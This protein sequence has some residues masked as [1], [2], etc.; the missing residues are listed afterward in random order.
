MKVTDIQTFV[1]DELAGETQYYWALQAI[2]D[3]DNVGPLS[4]IVSATTSAVPPSTISDLSAQ[5][6]GMYSA[7]LTFTAPGDDNE[8][9]TAAA[10]EIR[11][12]DYPL[13]SQ[14]FGFATLVE[15]PPT[16]LA[17]GTEQSLD[18]ENLD[19]GVL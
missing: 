2:D 11:Y 8:T 10:Y 5:A 17:A 16:P 7:T 6:T 12:A 14:N 9:G 1:V 15:S 18:I 19:A 13:S 3:A 4:E